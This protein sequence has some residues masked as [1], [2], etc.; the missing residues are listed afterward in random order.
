LVPSEACAIPTRHNNNNKP[1][2]ER[3]QTP[4]VTN[5]QL[6]HGK[7]ENN[8]TICHNPVARIAFKLWLAHLKVDRVKRKRYSVEI[9]E[10]Q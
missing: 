3:I 6:P 4:I 9:K 1:F 2:K 7:S 5:N 8:I 10:L